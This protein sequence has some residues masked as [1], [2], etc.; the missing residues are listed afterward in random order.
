MRFV[1]KK[2]QLFMKVSRGLIGVVM[3]AVIAGTVCGCKTKKDKESSE[4]EMARGKYEAEKNLVTVVPLE[5]KVFNKQ[6][7]PRNRRQD[8][9]QCRCLA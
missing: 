3:L 8:R 5:R 1:V 9:S 2:K 4:T 6:L 7:V